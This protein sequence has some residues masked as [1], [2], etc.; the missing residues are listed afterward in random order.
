MGLTV[1]PPNCGAA[2]AGWLGNSLTIQLTTNYGPLMCRGSWVGR[3]GGVVPSS[4]LFK[5]LHNTTTAGLAL[6]FNFKP[7][8]EV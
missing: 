6:G 4:D 5:T 1:T 2:A 3:G 8:D 7:E